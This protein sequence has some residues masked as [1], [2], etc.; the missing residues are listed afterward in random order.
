M[1][2]VGNFQAKMLSALTTADCSLSCCIGWTVIIVSTLVLL[3]KAIIWRLLEPN[4]LF[5]FNK[6]KIL[7]IVQSVLD[8]YEAIDPELAFG[9]PAQAK[10]SNP[11]KEICLTTGTK[12]KVTHKELF[13][14][15]AK[16]LKEHYGKWLDWD[17][18]AKSNNEWVFVNV[19]GT[20]GM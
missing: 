7:T 14:L 15:V 2:A 11:P 1:T 13:N 5:V 16:A 3:Y 6:D 20:M 18:S 12:T 10:T 8:K 17:D 9:F 19:G 4:F